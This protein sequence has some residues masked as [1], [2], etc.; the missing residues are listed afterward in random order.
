MSSK[1]YAKYKMLIIKNKIDSILNNKKLSHYELCKRIDFHQGSFSMI[2]NRKRVFSKNLIEKLIPILEVSKEEFE[3]WVLAEKYPK[4]LLKLAIEVRKAFPYK[5]KPILQNK[6]DA[7]LQQAEM[8]RTNLSKLINYNQ[9]GLN[10]MIT[11]KINM[12]KSVLEKT[13][14]ILDIPQNQL[15]SWII[16]DNYK[17]PLLEKAYQCYEN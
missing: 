11:G 14:N 10:R 16:A 17:L 3:S 1:N 4:E 12:S 5:R 9:S 13:A 6:L 2:L 8:S 15:Q 7:A